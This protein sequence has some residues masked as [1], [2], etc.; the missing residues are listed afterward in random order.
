[1][2]M[3]QD[4]VEVYCLPDNAYCELDE[5]KRSPF[6]I[7]DCPKGCKVCDGDCY[8]YKEDDDKYKERE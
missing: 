5:E 1:M 8:Y 3:V 2:E 4:G 7:D 6:D